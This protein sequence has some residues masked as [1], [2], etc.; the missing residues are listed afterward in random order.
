MKFSQETLMAYADGEL[1]A[2]TRRAI[3]AAM[4]A[5]AQIA[6]QIA[7]HRALRAQLASAF[8]GVLE[9]QV[10]SRLLESARTAPAGSAPVADL[11]VARARQTDQAQRRRW[12]WPEWTSIAASLLIGIFAGRAFL[13]VDPTDATALLGSDGRRFVAAGALAIAL[14][15]QASGQDPSSAID[16]V[17]SFRAKT[18]EYCRAFTAT[19]SSALT[20]L[21]CREQETWHVRI[22]GPGEPGGRGNHL[23]MAGAALPQP[24]LDVV[25]QLIDGDALDP[26]QEAA[27][28]ARGWH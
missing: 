17:L 28:R 5:D 20:G 1:D 2:Q 12:S 26:Q 6:E 18:G 14:S 25:T 27:A 10:P 21:A 23:R 7:R 13:K 3:E 22:L 11:A 4:A 9:E 16:I 8:D 19:Q 15:E 24:V